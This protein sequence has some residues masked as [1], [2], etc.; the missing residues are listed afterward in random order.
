MLLLCFLS[1]SGRHRLF[2]V[3]E[4][5][6]PSISKESQ[7]KMARMAA[8]A[9]WGIGNWQAM[10]EYTCMISPDTYDGAFYR[11]V[12]AIHDN[13]F[14]L[15]Q[16]VSAGNSQ[17]CNVSNAS[18]SRPCFQSMVLFSWVVC[19]LLLVVWQLSRTYYCPEM[20][21]SFYSLSSYLLSLVMP[22][23][24]L[25]WVALPFELCLTLNSLVWYFLLR[26]SVSIS[27]V[28][29]WTLSWR[30]WWERV[31]IVPIKYVDVITLHLSCLLVC[32]FTWSL[33]G[34]EPD[35]LAHD[36]VWQTSLLASSFQ[37]SAVPWRSISRFGLYW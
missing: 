25:L 30:P 8:S 29:F 19:R 4:E 24:L 7:Q 36:H 33:I 15:A 12:I 34:W 18:I 10:D 28:K 6:W 9:S 27:L 37:C 11:S 14:D 21:V 26:D 32:F 1:F 2:N 35:S 17:F 20:V 16:R 23:L 22:L 31:T 5:K 3:A 13:Q